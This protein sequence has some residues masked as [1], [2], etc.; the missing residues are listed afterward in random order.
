MKAY[1]DVEE[2]MV[3]KRSAIV[4]LVIHVLDFDVPI[5]LTVHWWVVVEMNAPDLDVPVVLTLGW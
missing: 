2:A 1:L 4:L 3:D 5:V